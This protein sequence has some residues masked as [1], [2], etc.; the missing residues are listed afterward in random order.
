[1]KKYLFHAI[2]FS[3]LSIL[4]ACGEAEPEKRIEP[5]KVSAWYNGGTLHKSSGLD[6]QKAD[7]KNKLATCGDFVSSLWNSGKLKDDI[8]GPIKAVDD[9]KPLAE[10]CVSMLDEAFSPDP[11]PNKNKQLFTNQKVA[12]FAVMAMMLDGWFK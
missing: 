12:D 4:F 6:W 2:I 11:D 5:K 9:M 8:A 3:C 1:M 7:K 10:Q